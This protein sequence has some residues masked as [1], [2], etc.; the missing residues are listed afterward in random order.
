MRKNR[1]RLGVQMKHLKVVGDFY[2]GMV[3]FAI[4]DWFK[5]LGGCPEPSSVYV[6]MFGQS[7]SR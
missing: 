4:G 1:Q 5:F 3:Y 2:G 6:E 7:A